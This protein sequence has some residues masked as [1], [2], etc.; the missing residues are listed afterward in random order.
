MQLAERTES[1]LLRIERE[2]SML[3]DRRLSLEAQLP[4]IKP[5]APVA[6][7]S[8]GE[9]ILSPAERL[10]ALQSQYAQRLREIQRRTIPTSGACSERSR[11]SRLRPAPRARRVTPRA[12]GRRHREEGR[13]RPVL[14]PIQRPDNPAY[15]AL[16]SQLESTRREL[17]HLAALRDDLRSETAH[18]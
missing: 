16:T 7:N 8:T 10:R 14:D 18:L 17:A 9:A 2:M 11:R 5:T 15:I 6:T 13:S 12:R 3:Q 1:E 4:L